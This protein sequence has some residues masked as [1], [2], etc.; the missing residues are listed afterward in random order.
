[1][2]DFDYY[3]INVYEYE[4]DDKTCIQG[5]K[6][7]GADGEGDDYDTVQ[8]TIRTKICEGT[9]IV[10]DENYSPRSWD[11]SAVKNMDNLFYP[12]TLDDNGRKTHHPHTKCNLDIDG[13]R[14][15]A[16]TSM[17]GMFLKAQSFNQPM[18]SWRVESVTDMGSMFKQTST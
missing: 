18:N 11:V 3:S 12:S 17:N 8:A 7:F 9:D 14:T 1:M 16:V 15:D 2:P 10:Y 4:T 6:G 5:K 13:W